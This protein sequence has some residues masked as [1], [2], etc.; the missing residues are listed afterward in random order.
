KLFMVLCAAVIAALMWFA[1]TA[2]LAQIS[3]RMRAQLE[4]RLSER[5]RIARELHDTLLQG[6]QGLMLR[7]QSV[8]DTIPA[9]QPARHLIEETMERSDAV[10][11]EG[12][13]RVR[14]L[15]GTETNDDLAQVIRDIAAKACPDAAP[16]FRV[17]VEGTPRPVHPIVS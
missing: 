16:D 9:D 17:V 7:F 11:A 12:R 5:E 4:A 15:R 6:F 14:N 13:D 2:R 8:A 10:L 1:Y 3:E